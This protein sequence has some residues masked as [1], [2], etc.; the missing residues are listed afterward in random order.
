MRTLNL[1]ER[2]LCEYTGKLFV[3]AK[4]DGYDIIDFVEKYMRCSVPAILD[5]RFYSYGDPGYL[6]LYGET[7]TVVTP[8]KYKGRNEQYSDEAIEWAG[9]IYR[10]WNWYTGEPSFHII[11]ICPAKKMLNSWFYGHKVDPEVFIEDMNN[12]FKIK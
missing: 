10:L 8:E 4:K 2:I 12:S 1:S 9:Y 7:L 5:T 11:D 3:E 6:Y